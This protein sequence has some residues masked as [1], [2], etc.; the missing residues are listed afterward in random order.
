[1]DRNLF[2]INRKIYF[3]LYAFLFFLNQSLYVPAQNT[4]YTSTNK[5][6]I[7]LYEEGKKFYQVY[8]YEQAIELLLKCLKEDPQFLEAYLALAQVYA[9]KNNLSEAEKN[10]RKALEINPS[11]FPRAYF[12]LGL[13]QFYQMK[14]EDA[15]KN[16]TTYLNHPKMNSS[17]RSTTER[18]IEQSRFASE[19]I[20]NPKKFN[21]VNLGPA[22][23]SSYDEYFPSIT[24][25]GLQFLFTRAIPYK[26]NPEFKNEDFFIS[27]FYQGKWQ[28]AQPVPSINS[29]GNEGAPSLSADGNILFF[30]S[31]ANQ[32]GDYGDPSRKGYGSCDIFYSVRING[33]WSKPKN[34]GPKINTEH[35]ETQPSF[36]S[37]G[38]TLYFI[39]GTVVRGEIKQQDIYMS[40]IDENGQ[41]TDAVKLSDVVNTPYKEESV[42]IHPDNKTLYFSSEGHTG[43]GGLD[44]FVTR[45]QDDGTW[46]KPVNLGY[47]INTASDENSLLAGPDGKLAFFASNRE[48]GYGGLDIYAFELP[49]E[50]QP[51]KITY[52]RG[53]IFDNKTKRP[54]QSKIIITELGNEQQTREA[55]PDEKGV[56]MLVLNGN[57][58]YV[59]HAEAKGYLLFS[60]AIDIPPQASLEKPF[61]VDIPMTPIDTGQTMVLKNI[62]FDVN[63]WDLKPESKTE[64]KKLADFLKKNPAVKI[65]ISG[66]TDNSG[67]KKFNATLSQNRAKAVYDYLVAQEK[68]SA[69]RLTYKGYADTRPLVPNTTPENK[70]I[71]R[72]TEYKIISK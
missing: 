54:V 26:E 72:R 3:I 52:V 1:M 48:G 32:F 8:K 19:Q 59:F 55:F 46:S 70:A 63:K 37:D 58:K 29:P 5:K 25:D 4:P 9:E 7:R 31:C 23:N 60:E 17:M 62:Y 6:A 49:A 34:A 24:A 11:F 45:K 53:K 28:E 41:F 12:E 18:Y 21:P 64:L 22:I 13:C 2:Q 33:Q 51:E 69:E 44:I 14:Y 10:Y 66:H 20:K 16:F 42:F 47:P 15:L 71:N 67:D 56:F 43:M 38:K 61:Q 35:W 27:T 30:A 36:S 68:I 57:K 39:R 40:T 50:V 65:E